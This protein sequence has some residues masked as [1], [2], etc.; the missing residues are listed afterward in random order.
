MASHSKYLEAPD[1]HERESG[2]FFT[3]GQV[4]F[5][6]FWIAAGGLQWWLRGTPPSGWWP[7][8]NLLP[9]AAAGASFDF[10]IGPAL[11]LKTRIRID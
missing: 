8:L 6:L 10:V 4:F 9:A 5:L 2:L 11:G 1:N 3:W 7:I